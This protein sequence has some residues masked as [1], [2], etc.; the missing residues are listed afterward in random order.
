MNLIQLKVPPDVLV[1]VAD[2]I[3]RDINQRP[4]DDT[5][6]E[7]VKFHTWLRYRLARWETRKDPTDGT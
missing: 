6:P 5:T 4:V 2:A 1:M 3:E 7:L